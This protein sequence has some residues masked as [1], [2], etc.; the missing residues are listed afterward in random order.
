MS[1]FTATAIYSPIQP[2]RAIGY[3]YRGVAIEGGKVCRFEA[4]NKELVRCR[5]DKMSAEQAFALIDAHIVN[6]SK[7]IDG[8][9]TVAQFIDHRNMKAGN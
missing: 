3:T 9:L 8:Y 1:Q 5:S 4:V 2:T 7:V 6:G